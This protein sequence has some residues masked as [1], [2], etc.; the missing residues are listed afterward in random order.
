MTDTA[1]ALALAR[2]KATWGDLASWSA[3]LR[4]PLRPPAGSELARDDEDFVGW[5]MSQLV[6]WGLAAARDHLQAIRIHLEARNLFP[7][8]T[9]TLLRGGLLGAAQAV[10]VLS[11]DDPSARLERSR[12]LAEEMMTRHEQYLSDL[13]KISP[14][15]HATTDL[16]RKH[17]TRRLGQLRNL[18]A[19]DGQRSKFNATDVIELAAPRPQ[20]VPISRLKHEPSGEDSQALPTALHGRR[21]VGAATP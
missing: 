20:L 9:G 14:E 17:V 8:A 18:R 16:V 6:H 11:P 21:S 1:N 12:A 4:V 5:P 13:R 2:I 19:Q 15:P 10:W 7:Y 3:R